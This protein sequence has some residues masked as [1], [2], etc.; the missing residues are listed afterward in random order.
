MPG[1]RASPSSVLMLAMLPF[2]GY[3]GNSMAY[4]RSSR[5]PRVPTAAEQAKLLKVTGEHVDG[6]RDHM[7]FAFALGTG[8]REK[9][10][11]SLNVGDV[12]RGREALP[13]IHLR[14]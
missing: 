4:V 6:F 7:I 5:A 13:R 1:S 10:I 2:C 8:L 9:E 3:T 14:E 11:A 12:S